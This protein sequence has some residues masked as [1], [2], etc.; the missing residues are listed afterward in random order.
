MGMAERQDIPNRPAEKSEWS[1]RRIFGGTGATLSKAFTQV[2]VSPFEWLLTFSLFV[3]AIG[4]LGDF[5]LSPFF[6]WV[7][8]VLLACVILRRAFSAMGEIPDIAE[9]TVDHKKK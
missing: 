4:E 6:Y 5:N 8:G 7:S 3:I 2:F 1:L 9:H